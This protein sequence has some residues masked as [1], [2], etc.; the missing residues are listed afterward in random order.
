M[1]Y[2]HDVDI[3][4]LTHDVTDNLTDNHKSYKS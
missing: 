3:H 1:I 2:R 4:M